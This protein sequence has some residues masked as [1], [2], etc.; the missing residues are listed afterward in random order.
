MRVLF[1]LMAVK[2]FGV[3]LL[4][5]VVFSISANTKN[6]G[7]WRHFLIEMTPFIYFKEVWYETGS[8]L[9]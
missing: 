9:W 8:Y 3:F 7:R 5:K 4:Q 2:D 6:V 1:A